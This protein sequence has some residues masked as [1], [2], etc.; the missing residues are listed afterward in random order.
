MPLRLPCPFLPLLLILIPCSTTPGLELVCGF[1]PASPSRMEAH[2][3][4][5]ALDGTCPE[6]LEFP[7]SGLRRKGPRGT[8]EGESVELSHSHL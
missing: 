1:F 8:E 7:F 5:S 3:L 2:P 4:A 6:K